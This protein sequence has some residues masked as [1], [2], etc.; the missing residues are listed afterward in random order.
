MIQGTPSIE[1]KIVHLMVVG[2][3]VLLAGV[4]FEPLHLRGLSRVKQVQTLFIQLLNETFE[5]CGKKSCSGLQNCGSF[6]ERRLACACW[7]NRVACCNDFIDF[8]Q[9]L[10]K[11]RIGVG[12]HIT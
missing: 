10:F 9:S 5:N 8:G 2:V 6:L 11:L 1:E 3:M 7:T 12:L 4:L